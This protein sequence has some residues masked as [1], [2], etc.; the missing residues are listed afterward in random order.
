MSTISLDI[1]KL[2]RE[3]LRQGK[4]KWSDGVRSVIDEVYEEVQ[5]RGFKTQKGTTP[6]RAYVGFIIQNGREWMDTEEVVK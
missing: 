2:T 6:K 3:M 4:V 1:V 5:Q